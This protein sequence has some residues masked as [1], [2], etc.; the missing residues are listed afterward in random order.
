[1]KKSRPINLE[2]TTLSFPPMAIASILHRLSGLAMIFLLPL[3]LYLLHGSLASESSFE[4]IRHFL[5]G[6]WVKFLVWVFVCA[7][8]YHI[9]AGVRHLL[10]DFGVGETLPAGRVSAWVVLGLSVLAFIGVGVWLC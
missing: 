4:S 7:L 9:L 1:M 6:V 5:D 2:L 10:M 8:I 3:M